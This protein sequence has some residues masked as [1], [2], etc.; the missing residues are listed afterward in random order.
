MELH[1]VIDG[2]KYDNRLLELAETAVRGIGD[3]R[4]SVKDAEKIF[5]SAR[6]GGAYTEV[7]RDTVEYIQHNYRWTESAIEWFKGKIASLS[8]VNEVPEIMTPEELSKQHFAK[9]DV[10]KDDSERQSRNH[11]LRS[12]TAET[13][14]DH[15]EIAIVVRLSNGKRVKVLS[16]FIEWG[17]DFV[18]LRGGFAIPVRAIEDVEV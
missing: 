18:E 9:H 3:G 2:K 16:N 17:G 6:D 11:D 7:E 15:D 1:K 4:I 13:Y 12:A 14:Q 8:F 5:E 10:L